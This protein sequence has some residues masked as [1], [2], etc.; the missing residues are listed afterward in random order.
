MKRTIYFLFAITWLVVGAA[1]SKKTTTVAANKRA[2]APATAPAAKKDNGLHKG[3]Y[4]NPNNPHHPS[5]N[6]GGSTKQSTTV[7]PKHVNHSSKEAPGN[8]GKGKGKGSPGNSGKGNGN[9][10]KGNGKK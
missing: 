7:K 1:C 5:H 4:K 9:G 10:G 6:T 8:S 2:P 3:W